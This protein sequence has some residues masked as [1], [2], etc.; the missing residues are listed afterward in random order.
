MLSAGSGT[1]DK[2]MPQRRGQLDEVSPVQVGPPG[3]APQEW[4]VTLPAVN[5]AGVPAS[6]RTG[7]CRKEAESQSQAA[8]VWFGGG[9]QSVTLKWACLRR[10]GIPQARK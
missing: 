3:S 5:A 1:G 2:M 7:K 6:A 4:H 9:C 10:R 8:K